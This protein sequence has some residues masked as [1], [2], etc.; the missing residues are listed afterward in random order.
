M[1]AL[2]D[3]DDYPVGDGTQDRRK[4][5]AQPP[6]PEELALAPGRAEI[7]DERTSSRLAGSEAQ[8]REMSGQP[9]GDVRFRRR[10]ENDGCKPAGKRQPDRA[11]VAEPI[12]RIA[13]G[14]RT[15]RRRHVH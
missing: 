14:E 8:A 6:Q 2:G 11:L 12:L 15:E 9:E 5:D 3:R 10:G 7:A 4:L 13:E 1:L